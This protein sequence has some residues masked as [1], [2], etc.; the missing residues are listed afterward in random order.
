VTTS[1]AAVR[2]TA[3]VVALKSLEQAKSRLALPDPLRRRLAWT[4]A[5]DTLRALTSALPHVLVVSDQPALDARLRR[6]G[7]SVAVLG[8]SSRVGMNPALDNGAEVLRVQGFTTVLACVGDLP[9]LRAESII[10]VL[11]AAECSGADRAFLADAS[12]V[13]TT[14]LI[15]HDTPLLPHFQGRSAAAHHSSGAINLAGTSLGAVPDAQRDVDT[16]IELH[17]AQALG[18]GPATSALVDHETGRLGRHQ[19]ITA[20]AWR[21]PGGEQQAVTAA[22]RRVALPAGVLAEDLRQVRS[23]QRLH[24]VVAADDHVLSAWLT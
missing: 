15:A 21:G 9:A 24:A 5:L 11:A 10:R 4:M 16:G 17:A 22:G 1:S 2:G 19:V 23:G 7:L 18:L 13:G 6:A 14:M 12:G 8:D 3:A 20:T